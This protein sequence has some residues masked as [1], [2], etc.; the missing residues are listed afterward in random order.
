M[1]I[2][3]PLH[4][5]R[6][7][8]VCRITTE[9]TNIYLFSICQRIQTND[10]SPRLNR[11]IPDPEGEIP[12]AYEIRLLIDKISLLFA[13]IGISKVEAVTVGSDPNLT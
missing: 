5:G 8:S 3:P 11:M 6:S 4:S 2:T 12:A 13:S 9:T 7:G 10:P 1:K